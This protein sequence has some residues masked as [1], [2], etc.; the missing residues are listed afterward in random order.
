MLVG[1]DGVG[2]TSVA[3]AL[4]DIHYAPVAYVHFRPSP[5]SPLV[6]RPEEHDFGVREKARP[7]GSMVIGWVRAF[8]SVFV[9]WVGYLARVRPALR[10][11][12]L[13]VGDRWGYGYLAQPTALRFYGPARL[14][15]FLVRII[16]KPDVLVNLTAP[17]GVIEQ[18]KRELTPDEI[19]AELALWASL[20]IRGLIEIDSGPDPQTVARRIYHLAFP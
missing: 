12:A 20:P 16:P 7:A 15:R 11:G 2:K 9:F 1:P 4:L 8:F 3:R 13:V 10:G 14:G 5:F 17:V 6:S 19:E 18:R